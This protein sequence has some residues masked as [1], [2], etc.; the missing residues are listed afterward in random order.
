MK[1]L[2]LVAFLTQMQVG[3]SFSRPRVSDDNPFIESFF[4]TVKYHVSYPK[5]FTDISMAREWFADFINWYNER[6]Q[7]SALGYVTPHQKHTGED[8]PIFDKRQAV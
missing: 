5:A 3:L 2:S 4:K 6:H 7:H 1:G 8:V